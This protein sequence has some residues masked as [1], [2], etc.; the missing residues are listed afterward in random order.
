[1]Y[2]Y[3]GQLKANVTWEYPAGKFILIYDHAD[4]LMQDCSNP[5]VLAMELL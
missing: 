3:N 5:S 4:G 2:F 1:M